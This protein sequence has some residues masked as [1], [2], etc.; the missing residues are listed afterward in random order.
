MITTP[1]ANLNKRGTLRVLRGR[2]KR[3]LRFRVGLGEGVRVREVDKSEG[4][5]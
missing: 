5:R 2:R 1:V 3:E 4:Q